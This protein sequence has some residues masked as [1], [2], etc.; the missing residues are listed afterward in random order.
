MEVA[1]SPKSKEPSLSCRMAVP[2]PF[3]AALKVMVCEAPA[4]FTVTEVETMPSIWLR[5]MV[6]VTMVLAPPAVLPSVGVK[7]NQLTL[8]LEQT[9]LSEVFD[10]PVFI[11]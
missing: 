2:V 3:E 7:V 10:G 4:P 9:Q 11:T 8:I 6:A 5:S 1:V